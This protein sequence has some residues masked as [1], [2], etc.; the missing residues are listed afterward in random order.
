MPQVKQDRLGT[1]IA[2]HCNS[3]QNRAS[4]ETNR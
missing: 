4:Q 3:V 2:R 1:I